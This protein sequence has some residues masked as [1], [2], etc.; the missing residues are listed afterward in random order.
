[1]E[2]ANTVRVSVAIAY[3]SRA[4]QTIDVDLGPV[5]APSE[6]VSPSLAVMK[7]LAV[8]VPSPIPCLTISAQLAQKIHA[9]TNPRII[10]DPKQDRAKDLID[11]I[12][13]TDLGQNDEQ[14]VLLEATEVFRVRDEHPWPPMLPDYPESWRA[15]M[16]RLA[17]E[18]EH[19][20]R[21]A[22]LLIARFST[23]LT[24]IVGKPMK[25]EYEY[26]FLSLAEAGGGRTAAVT[27]AQRTQN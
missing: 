6:D 21:S 1:M 2:A 13:L 7:S 15:T 20:D 8:P 3:E 22:E 25:F 18:I 14:A 5:E 4:F 11:I 23:I 16:Q 27:E 26:R 19:P 9:V 12:V 24:A 17:A 10:A